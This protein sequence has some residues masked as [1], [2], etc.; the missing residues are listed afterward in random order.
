[1]NK[2]EVHALMPVITK[3]PLSDFSEMDTVTASRLERANRSRVM[4][5]PDEIA[6]SVQPSLATFHVDWL[7]AQ[8]KE[9]DATYD[10]ILQN[11]LVEWLARHP[12]A[13][14]SSLVYGEVMRDALDEFIP[15][16]SKEFM[17]VP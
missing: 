3:M 12:E 16:H 8:K 7:N 14:K 10:E 6:R 9:I 4:R 15:R 11:V 5:K 17:P 1:V 13:L 2:E